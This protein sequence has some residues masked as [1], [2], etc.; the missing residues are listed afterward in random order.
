MM[1]MMSVWRD[2]VDGEDIVDGGDGDA[3][4]YGANDDIV[5]DF[6]DD[7]GGLITCYL[8]HIYI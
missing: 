7:C 2:I 6:D 4:H 1:L 3:A 8:C 5:D